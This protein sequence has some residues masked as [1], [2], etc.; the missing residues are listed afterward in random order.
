MGLTVYGGGGKP[1][2]EKTVTAGTSVKVV[3]PSDGKTIKKVTINP[4][5]SQSKTVTPSTSQQTVSPDSGKLLSQVIVKAMEDVTPEVTAQTPVITQIAENLGIT[6]TIPSGTNKQKLQANNANLA[7][8]SDY[9]PHGA[10][11]WKK[12]EIE[13]ISYPQT[14][15]TFTQQNV[16]KTPATLKVTCP[17]IDLTQVDASFFNGVSGTVQSTNQPYVFNDGVL[18][19]E[20]STKLNFTYDAY[21]T[22]IYIDTSWGEITWGSTT[23]PAG[24]IVKHVYSCMVVSDEES[25]YPDGGEQDGYWYEK[26]VE[27]I[28]LKKL[29]GYTKIVID[30]FTLSSDTAANSKDIY[31]S[32]GKTPKR[33][34]VVSECTSPS[35][36]A[37]V[38][39]IYSGDEYSMGLLVGY[40]WTGNTTKVWGRS[41]SST[42]FRANADHL[43]S[44]SSTNWKAG[45]EYTLITMA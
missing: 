30:K 27:G 29:F 35:H 1:E 5:P 18:T 6:I 2:E 25:A 41:G 32:L 7:K 44:T 10:Y 22:S 8:I 31:H 4:T 45:V 11:V 20:S 42:S 9:L 17:D 23:I 21:A 19:I 37:D 16:G 40:Y 28:D 39:T 33:I 36:I 26:V 15:L 3:T 43:F 13:T 14:T 38:D 34:L 24:E 12:Y